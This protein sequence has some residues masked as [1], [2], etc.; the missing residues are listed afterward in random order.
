LTLDVVVQNVTP[1]GLV[2]LDLNTRIK[3]LTGFIRVGL[4]QREE[5]MRV[6][7]FDTREIENR[8]IVPDGTVFL[9]G[10]MKTTRQIERR[11]GVPILSDLPLLRHLTSSRRESYEDAELVFLV[12]PEV[13]SRRATLAKMA[14]VEE[15]GGT[16]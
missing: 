2:V 13:L 1:E 5:P 11:R 3:D 12:K 6:P 9:A 4:N 7:T 10:V 15:E 8:L 16:P 14:A